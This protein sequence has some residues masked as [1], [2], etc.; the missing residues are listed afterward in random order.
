MNINKIRKELTKLDENISV[1]ECWRE[2]REGLHISYDIKCN[3]VQFS[4]LTLIEDE[5]FVIDMC[6]F[7]FIKNEY[8]RVIGKS[9]T[10]KCLKF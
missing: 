2:E 7:S 10:P 8:Y 6:Q 4:Y 5:D 1:V 9:F 3:G